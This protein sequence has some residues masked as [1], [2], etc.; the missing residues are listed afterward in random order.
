MQTG[1]EMKAAHVF[2]VAINFVHHA[3]RLNI[4]NPE[5]PSALSYR[6]HLLTSEIPHN[7]LRKILFFIKDMFM[8]RLLL[9]LFKQARHSVLR[10]RG[11]PA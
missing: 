3:I 11:H 8:K 1:K 4:P 10:N 6:T 5:A 9:S 2:S 7:F